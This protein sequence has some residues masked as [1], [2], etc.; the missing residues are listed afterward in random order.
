M[1]EQ[2]LLTLSLMTATVCADAQGWKTTA[3]RY[4]ADGE[5]AKTEW[6]LRGL[7]QAEKDAH[8]LQI[9]SLNAIMKRIRKDFCIT[10]AEGKLR[11]EEIYGH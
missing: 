10:P 7:P 2:L 4:I 3:E 8:S 6:M 9:D 1:K 5:F 11:I